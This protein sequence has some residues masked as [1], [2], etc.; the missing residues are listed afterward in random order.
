MTIFLAVWATGWVL[1][2]AH[3]VWSET[4]YRCVSVIEILG[5][6]VFLT[7]LWPIP[8]LLAEIGKRRGG[9]S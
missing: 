8:V 9:G 7:V 2:T 4:R 5:M 3:L 6:A 1:T